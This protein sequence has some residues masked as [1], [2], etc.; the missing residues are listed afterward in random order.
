M[1]GISTS[2]GKGMISSTGCPV[3][4]GIWVR[5]TSNWVFCA[6]FCQHYV[7]RDVVSVVEVQEEGLD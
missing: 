1:G 4:F 7:L 2:I 5:I 6:M 3:R